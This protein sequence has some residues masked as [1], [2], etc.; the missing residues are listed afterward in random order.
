MGATDGKDLKVACIRDSGLRRE[1]DLSRKV[2]ISCSGTE[3]R[4]I[5]MSAGS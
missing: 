2:F 1:E 4:G 3:Q 5:A